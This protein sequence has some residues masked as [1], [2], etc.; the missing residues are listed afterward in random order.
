MSQSSQLIQIFNENNF[1][2]QDMKT[3][4]DFI[5]IYKDVDPEDIYIDLFQYLKYD[6]VDN[7]ISCL[8]YLYK[9]TNKFNEYIKKIPTNLIEK[10]THNINKFIEDANIESD[11]STYNYMI[12]YDY[13]NQNQNQNQITDHKVAKTQLAKTFE[14][15]YY[16]LI[17]NLHINLNND[18]NNILD[19]KH[20]ANNKL[21]INSLKEAVETGIVFKSISDSDIYVG[22]IKSFGLYDQ[23]KNVKNNLLNNNMENNNMENNN[24]ENNNTSHIYLHI[25]N[26]QEINNEKILTINVSHHINVSSRCINNNIVI[27]IELFYDQEP[28]FKNNNIDF[29]KLSKH[30]EHIKN[31]K[32][33]INYYNNTFGIFEFDY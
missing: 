25:F 2:K 1:N 29:K 14:S 18:N 7:F 24:M 22:K 11:L 15:A 31:Y 21:Y 12:E 16:Y 13:I 17:G 3:A 23:I 8:E 26:I 4:E 32:Q 33:I 19:I 5:E 6:F 10:Y 9:Y 20:I 27:P 30:I 28:I